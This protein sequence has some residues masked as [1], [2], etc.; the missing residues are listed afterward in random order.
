M[1]LPVIV[2][3]SAGAALLAK[4]PIGASIPVTGWKIGTGVLPP[5]TNLQNQT[6]LVSPLAEIPI[7]SVEPDGKQ[8]LI[9]GQFVN[10]SMEAFTWEETGLFASDPD[11]GTILFAYGNSFG[12][13]EAIPAGS[14]Q[15]QEI[16]FGAQMV[17]DVAANITAVI[18]QGLVFATLK[19]LEQ[20]IP[21]SEKGHP[22]G[23]ATLDQNGKVPE[24]QLPD[25]MITVGEDGKIPEDKLPESVVTTEPDGKIPEEKLSK[26]ISDAVSTIKSHVENQ[27]NPHKVTAAQV[28]ADPSGSAA[29]VQDN[30]NTH[31]SNRSNP[32][33]VT[34][35]QVGAYSKEE[36][37]QAIQETGASTITATW[38]GNQS[39]KVNISLSKKAKFIA[40]RVDFASGSGGYNGFCSSAIPGGNS[41]FVPFHMGEGENAYFWANI[42]LSSDGL[43]ASITPRTGR[44]VTKI[45][46]VALV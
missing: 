18:D 42:F 30:L 33:G 29:A 41:S 23:V 46:I 28:G 38:S 39:S 13:G 45:E 12:S 43:T 9:T 2:L 25:Q 6:A 10:T 44:N 5:G 22:D 1:G 15:L 21:C 37:L 16:V 24:E 11:N 36:T 14:S 34:A 3:T 8:C 31:T 20:R 35:A 17:F 19:Q 7:A 4:T 27:G 40:A 32:H 26:E